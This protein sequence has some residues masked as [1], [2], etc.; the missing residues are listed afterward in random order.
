MLLCLTDARDARFLGGWLRGMGAAGVIVSA[1][2]LDAAFAAGEAARYDAAIIDL[3]A[4]GD[5]DQTMDLCLILR[6]AAPALPIVVL[7]SETGSADP[8]ALRLGLCHAE[9]PRAF[10][11]DEAGR[12]LTIALRRARQGR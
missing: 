10:G 6:Q 9:L 3:D 7:R 5:P 1:E 12:A 11:P 4:L 8:L 2:R